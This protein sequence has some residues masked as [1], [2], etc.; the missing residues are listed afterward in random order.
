MAKIDKR[1]S[2]SVQRSLFPQYRDAMRI[3]YEQ[4]KGSAGVA[5]I[6]ALKG[7]S[8]DHITL[9]PDGTL[10]KHGIFSALSDEQARRVIEGLENIAG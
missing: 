9:H 8:D 2:Q 7:G 5:S 4:T 1:L 3:T 6:Y 10:N